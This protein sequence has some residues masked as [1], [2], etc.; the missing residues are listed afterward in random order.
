[1]L[2][3]RGSEDVLAVHQVLGD[4]ESFDPEGALI[5]EMR[6]FGGLSVPETARALGWSEATVHR[7][8]RLTRAWLYDALCVGAVP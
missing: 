8:W 5:V 2:E 6:F 4:L 3:D 7:R 1:M